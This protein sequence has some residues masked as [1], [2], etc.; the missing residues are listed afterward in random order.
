MSKQLSIWDVLTNT[1]D[2][3]VVNNDTGN[4][5]DDSYVRYRED[6]ALLAN[7]SLNSY[8]FSISWPRI[9]T[10]EGRVNPVA[11]AHYNDLIDG[12][13]AHG[14][15][16]LVTLYHGDLPYIWDTQPNSTEQRGWRN[17]TYLLPK[18]LFYAN[19]CFSAFGDRVKHWVTINEPRYIC[20]LYQCGHTAILVHAHTVRAYRALKQGGVIGMVIDGSFSIPLTRSQADVDAA[21]RALVFDVGLFAD[22]IFFGDYPQLM[23]DVLGDRL[24][25]FTDD[26]RALLR[27]NVPDYFFLKYNRPHHAALIAP[28]PLSPHSA[29][30]HA[31]ADGRLRPL[32]CLI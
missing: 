10:A 26:E 9:V 5:A 3:C 15:T 27:A 11:V 23:R 24:P 4:T 32:C 1:C 17:A 28:A 30:S 8:R 20:A 6:T 22:P 12:L 31:F 13:L 14:I 29:P 7:L 16:P 2:G 25:R 18:F 19:A 21:E